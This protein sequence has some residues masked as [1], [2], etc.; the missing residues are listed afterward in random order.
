MDSNRNSSKLIKT[1]IPE[2]RYEPR[3]WYLEN[4]RDLPGPWIS[5]SHFVP[6]ETVKHLMRNKKDSAIGVKFMK[7][8]QNPDKIT[9]ME[10]A[11]HKFVNPIVEVTMHG[12]YV[13]RDGH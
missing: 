7:S 1:P 6:G 2:S 5:H 9:N 13:W 12:D 3:P 11:L 10:G 8:R 4:Y